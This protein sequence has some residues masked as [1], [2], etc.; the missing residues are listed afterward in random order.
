[1]DWECKNLWV[2]YTG[3]ED[4]GSESVSQLPCPCKGGT[5]WSSSIR[6]S[7]CTGLTVNEIFIITGT[8][9]W[10]N[11]VICCLDAGRW[12]IFSGGSGRHRGCGFHDRSWHFRRHRCCGCCSQDGRDF[13]NESDTSI[14][15]NVGVVLCRHVQ[16]FQ[17]IVIETG[18]L[19]LEET[20]SVLPSYGY[21]RL[22]VEDR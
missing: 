20:P 9:S 10:W 6:A 21:L 7:G 5:E 19:A 2:Y 16:H 1:M 4:D 3:D 17:A 18:E 8:F 22:G 13:S 11:D 15:F 12:T 14:D